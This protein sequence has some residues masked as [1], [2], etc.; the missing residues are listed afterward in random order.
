M[1]SARLFLNTVVIIA[2]YL[3]RSGTAEVVLTLCMDR[4]QYT[5]SFWQR[6]RNAKCRVF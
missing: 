4:Q 3:Q 2:S 1:P 5:V 6:M